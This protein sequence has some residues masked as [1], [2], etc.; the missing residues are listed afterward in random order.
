MEVQSWLRGGRGG[1]GNSTVAV[2]SLVV[3]AAAWRKRDKSRLSA[4]K[5]VAT[6]RMTDC[7]L[8]YP[9][10]RRW[11]QGGRLTALCHCCVTIVCSHDG[12]GGRGGQLIVSHHRLLAR[13]W[14][15]GGWLIVFCYYPFAWQWRQGGCLTALCH[16]CVAIVCLHGSGGGV[17]D[18]L[19]LLLF[20]CIGDN[21]GDDCALG[22]GWGLMGG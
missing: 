20:V 19:C 10:V 8:H 16:C 12:G 17:D 14:W 9:I 22:E 15:W 1:D 18:W 5:A 3:D 21:G 2:A 6:G 7:V 11:R 4:G 13:W